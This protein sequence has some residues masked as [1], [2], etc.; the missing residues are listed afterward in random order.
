MDRDEEI[1]KLRDSLVLGVEMVS[2][3]EGAKFRALEELKETKALL[4]RY[5]LR[6]D[7][8]LALNEALAGLRKP[9]ES[10]ESPD[11]LAAQLR[12]ASAKIEGLRLDVKL[13]TASLL[14][15]YSAVESGDEMRLRH[16]MGALKIRLVREGCIRG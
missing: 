13:E 15:L 5:R 9:E 4:D 11:L 3:A 10:K 14:G 8:E 16:M 2:Q 12:L 6:A 7:N 1:K